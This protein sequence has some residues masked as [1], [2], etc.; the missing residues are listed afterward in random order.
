MGFPESDD[1]RDTEDEGID[2]P[3][4]SRSSLGLRGGPCGNASA[5]EASDSASEDDHNLLSTSLEPK[6]FSQS[7]HQDDSDDGWNHCRDNVEQEF[8]Q[9]LSCFPSV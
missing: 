7:L 8:Q 5:A 9:G 2:E 1:N 4:G 3:D 6:Y